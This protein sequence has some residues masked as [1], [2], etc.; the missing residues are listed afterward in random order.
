MKRVSGLHEPVMKYEFK[1]LCREC[2]HRW[3][4]VIATDN[5]LSV[6]DPPC[7]SCKKAQ[8]RLENFSHFD[9]AGGRAPSIGGNPRVVAQDQ[10]AE[11][12]MK[13]HGL[14]DLRGPTEARMGESSAPKLPPKLQSMADMMFQPQRQMQHA[15]M[16]A[17]AGII[18][19][20]A[21]AGGYSPA[22][23]NSPDPIAIAQSPRKTVQEVAN[24][25]NAP[26]KR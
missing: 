3:K 26:E 7:P 24:I 2:G 14:T 25:M 19:R 20:Q 9:P 23:T 6:M 12:I 10:A 1:W 21:M 4:R 17:H 18:A 13:D 11:I 8:K 5:P 15:G 22:A 16:G